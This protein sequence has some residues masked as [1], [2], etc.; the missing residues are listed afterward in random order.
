MAKKKLNLG[1][2]ID[3]LFTATQNRLEY[4]RKSDATIEAMRKAE[5]EIESLIIKNFEKA[6]IE[7]A[8]GKLCTATVGLFVAPRVE[9]WPK[10]WAHIRKTNAFD[11]LE[12]R[13]AKNACRERWEAKETIPGV[14][15][16]TEKRLYLN[17]HAKEK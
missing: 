10:F 6:D 8:R 9:D 11:L 2:L 1:E 16:F 17:K 3:G 5:A 4:Q 15:Q 12:K 13:P 7:A 14:E